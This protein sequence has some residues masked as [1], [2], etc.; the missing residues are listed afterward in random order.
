MLN[1]LYKLLLTLNSTSW[2]IVIFCIKEEYTLWNLPI[3]LFDIILFLIPVILSA[4][5]LLLALGLSKDTLNG[6][7]EIE[8]SNNSFIPT[9]LGYFFVGLSITSWESLIFVYLIIF[10]FTYLSQNQYFNPIYLL[11]GFKFYNI[12]TNQGVKIFVIAKSEIRF[13]S[14]ATFNKL[15]RINNTTFIE[16]RKKK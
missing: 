3:I 8:N 13:A 15:R 7:K 1:F 9:Y 16:L 4:I 14:E 2:V 11:F 6:G 5:S 12:S 10:I